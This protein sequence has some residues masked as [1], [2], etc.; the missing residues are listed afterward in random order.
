MTASATAVAGDATTFVI[1]GG[2][3]G[4][5]A[6]R[7]RRL[8]NTHILHLKIAGKYGLFV[9]HT[10]WAE[11]GADAITQKDKHRGGRHIL[12]IYGLT[13]DP[14]HKPRRMPG[15]PVERIR[16]P[17]AFQVR[18]GIVRVLP[19]GLLDCAMR[20]AEMHRLSPGVILGDIKFR[21][22]LLRLRHQPKAR[23][24]SLPTGI[25]RSNFNISIGK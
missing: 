25:L 18:R 6:T 13:A 12:T 2:A 21:R 16:V 8:I 22:P 1:A 23:P 10:G 17:S 9:R 4:A 5:E 15:S 19:Q 11:A 24:Q 14:I 20:Q 3:T 7:G